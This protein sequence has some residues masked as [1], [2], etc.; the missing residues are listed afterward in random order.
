MRKFD[1]GGIREFL[2]LN[3]S[4]SNFRLSELVTR[5]VKRAPDNWE[6]AIQELIETKPNILFGRLGGLEASCLGIYL[7]TRKG[8]RNPI[9]YLKAVLIAPRRKKQLK[10][11]AGVFPNEKEIFDFFANEHLEALEQIDIFSVWA[12]PWAWVESKYADKAETMFVTGDA[13]YP[14]PEARDGLSESGWGM[15][16]D[17]KRVL[18][19]SPFIDSFEVQAQK[20]NEIFRG[21]KYP[22]MELQFLRAPMTQGGLK[23]GTTYKSH[24]LDLKNQMSQREF[25]VALI[26]AGA[27]SLPLAAHAKK[28]GKT[29]IHAGGALQ[30]FFG[31]TGQRYDSYSQVKRFLN[32]NWK[33]PFEHERPVNWREIEDGCY[34]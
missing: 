11:N 1:F 8:P 3:H 34:W 6:L 9:R 12:K 27:Y 20:I 18:L 4:R 17:R 2:I 16:L 10:A 33:R 25:D 22:D 14:W 5:K 26:S 19:V 28:I 30:L 31:V 24:L 21:I 7:D 15:A 32:S 13:S 29:G 23:D